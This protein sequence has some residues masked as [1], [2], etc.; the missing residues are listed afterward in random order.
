MQYDQ[1]FEQEL[2]QCIE[3]ESLG[4]NHSSPTAQYH[5]YSSSANSHSVAQLTNFSDVL[6][7]NEPDAASIAAAVGSINGTNG[8][9]GISN[10]VTSA[11]NGLP[12]SNNLLPSLPV[13]S[14]GST[15]NQGA[16][17][18]WGNLDVSKS[19]G[20]T[21]ILS[22]SS[23]AQSY[24]PASSILDFNKSGGL[25]QAILNEQLRNGQLKAALSLPSSQVNGLMN[26]VRASLPQQQQ[27]QQLQATQQQVKS[28]P[29]TSIIAQ[30]F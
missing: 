9:P 4:S 17:N 30:L 19:N 1:L 29:L 23:L 11:P 2:A 6:A 21:G 12:S 7:S 27:Q 5:Q 3:S 10:G 22:N 18:F 14:N 26:T 16:S 15:V 28:H 20:S 8:A 13:L 25:N 24:Q